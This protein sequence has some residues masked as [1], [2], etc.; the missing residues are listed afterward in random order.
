MANAQPD[1]PEEQQGGGWYRM[2]L[3]VVL[4]YFA[5]NAATS[6]IGGKFGPQKD[7]A[8]SDG[9]DSS[10]ANRG[11]EAIPALWSLGTKMVCLLKHRK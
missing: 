6:L 8:S 4:I 5:M 9:G 1:A 2:A 3:N 11:I 7:V 10:T